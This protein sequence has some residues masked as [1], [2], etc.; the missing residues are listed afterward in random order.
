MVFKNYSQ[1]NRP[2]NPRDTMAP[3]SGII[4]FFSRHKVAAN[5][6]MAI[7]ILYGAFGIT[8]LKRQLMPDFGLELIS[9]DVE[10]QGASAEDI[11]SNIIN[12]V[13]P[14][15]RFINGVKEVNSTAFEGRAKMLSLIHI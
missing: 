7:L 6:L 2:I 13:E 1:K 12:A 10:W 14:E 15:V 4:A 8:Q 3:N 9:V 5:L 11:E